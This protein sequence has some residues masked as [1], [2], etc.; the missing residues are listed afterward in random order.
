MTTSPLAVFKLLC[1]V[2]VLSTT[3][4]QHISIAHLP[5]YQKAL[6]LGLWICSTPL[7]PTLPNHPTLPQAPIECMV[8]ILYV[9]LCRTSCWPVPACILR[10][11]CEPIQHSHRLCQEGKSST[12]LETQGNSLG[13]RPC[14]GAPCLGGLTEA[15]LELQDFASKWQPCTNAQ[16]KE[17]AQGSSSLVA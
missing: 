14:L 1:L 15:A 5:D 13:K 12:D 10:S 4:H 3:L 16:H 17:A 7:P 11:S 6:S 8:M 2:C 9:C